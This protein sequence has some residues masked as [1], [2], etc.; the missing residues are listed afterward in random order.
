MPDIKSD[1]REFTGQVISWLNEFIT[2]G[3]Y[4]FEVAS[5]EH[6]IKEEFVDSKHLKDAKEIP[7]PGDLL[8]LGAY[9]MGQQEVIT[10][11]GFKYEASGLDEAK[12]IIYAQKPDSFLIRIP[13]KTGTLT[14]A[15]EED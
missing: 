4:P 12:F 9:F 3:S 1:E 7:V 8:E 11:N 2:K 5:S 14:N 10:D 15:I 6:S 13:T